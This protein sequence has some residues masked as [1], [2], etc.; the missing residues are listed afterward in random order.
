MGSCIACQNPRDK[1]D[2]QSSSHESKEARDFVKA[3]KIESIAKPSLEA[4]FFDY[5]S[6]EVNKV[7]SD[8]I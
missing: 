3:Q 2:E 8:Y 6:C 4:E 7:I 5:I 1:E